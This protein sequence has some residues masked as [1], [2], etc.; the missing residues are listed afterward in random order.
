MKP[1]KFCGLVCHTAGPAHS[2]GVQ[3]GEAELL[4]QA[5]FVEETPIEPSSKT[6]GS[7]V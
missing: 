7:T 3:N 4:T 1:G 5:S 6:L 2:G